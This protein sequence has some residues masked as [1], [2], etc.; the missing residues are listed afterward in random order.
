MKIQMTLEQI[1]E[2]AYKNYTFSSDEYV[3]HFFYKPI[4]KYIAINKITNDDLKD[5]YFKNIDPLNA[6]L[7]TLVSDSAIFYL[8]NFYENVDSTD[9]YQML[10]K[11]DLKDFI[12]DF[13]EM[14]EDL[15]TLIMKYIT[16][17]IA[18]YR[19]IYTL[20]LS[21]KKDIEFVFDVT[22][23][24]IDNIEIGKGDRHFNLIPTTEIRFQDRNIYFKNRVENYEHKLLYIYNL[25]NDKEVNI[26]TLNIKEGYFQK[27]VIQS[28]SYSIDN[29]YYK[30][31]QM[32]FTSYL[33][34]LSDL[35]EEN[36][37]FD[38]E[39]Y[40]PI[41]CE[42]IFHIDE[43]IESNQKGVPYNL[44]NSVLATGLLPFTSIKGAV[45]TGFNS[46]ENQTISMPNYQIENNNNHFE[47]VFN[48]KEILMSKKN[49]PL[50]QKKMDFYKNKNPF[51]KGFKDSYTYFLRNKEVIV[52]KIKEV[53]QNKTSR[54]LHKNTAF[55][56]ELLQ[57]SYHP[58]LFLSN[59][60]ESFI[61]SKDELSD[62]EKKHILQDCIPIDYKKIDIKDSFFDKFSINDLDL[63]IAIINQSFI[64]EK[65]FYYKKYKGINNNTLS[66]N[67]MIRE[68]L[69]VLDATSFV[70]KGEVL[71]FD[72][73]Y[74]G[75]NENN[76]NFELIILPKEM[77]L[78]V[79]GLALFLNK[80][81]AKYGDLQLIEKYR[82]MFVNLVDYIEDELKNNDVKLGFYDGISGVLYS[83]F[84]INK[85]LNYVP[86]KKFIE[87][88][89]SLLPYIP[90]QKDKDYDIIN[91]VI[92]YLHYL[93]KIYNNA[94]ENFQNDIYQIINKTLDFFIENNLPKALKETYIGF[95]HGVAGELFVIQEANKICRRE[96]VTIQINK[97]YTT[98]N[99]YFNESTLGWP[100][101]NR[102]DSTPSNWCHGAPGVSLTYLSPENK[103]PRNDAM[104]LMKNIIDSTNENICLCHGIVGNQW[105]IQ[106]INKNYMNNSI[107]DSHLN[108]LIEKNKKVILN[109]SNLFE[110][111]KS[112]MV[113]LPGVFDYYI[114][115]KNSYEIF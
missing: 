27:K 12:T 30:A 19:N 21:N 73:I 31:G 18:Q 70:Y 91:G 65:G 52:R 16:N 97:L 106:Y 66:I 36:I 87:W 110:Y 84:L 50:N 99:S 24:K 100:I 10:H 101:S 79:S 113:G 88:S 75:D 63:Q 6:H 69:D 98:L 86:E 47:K 14:F 28:D 41:D 38:G 108:Y 17:S 64:S 83:A 5:L 107:P 61:E 80:M 13:Y 46:F 102:D 29:T 60:R 114:S 9:T 48:E 20:L 37:V 11:I 53:F 93:T 34:G 74:T 45:I 22:L 51:I 85:E 55:Y 104:K 82:L 3:L 67:E 68:F 33:L 25:F 1:I 8:N 57:S 42:T 112:Y 39:N 2:N 43:Y 71:V 35:H 90:S 49:I 81:L 7:N 96:D 40:I 103:V 78:G 56:Y 58:Y 105:V 62:V 77:Y 59:T 92:G 95:A 76:F 26:K 72:H 54:V 15:W 94:S 109:E 32:L 89:G 4:H 111:S 44:Q 23:N 115:K